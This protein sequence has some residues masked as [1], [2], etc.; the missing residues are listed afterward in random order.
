MD[1]V[2]KQID[3]VWSLL[4]GGDRIA[5]LTSCAHPA[6]AA[7]DEIAP[8]GP[9]VFAITRRFTLDPAA[10]AQAIRLTLDVVAEYRAT[11]TLIP[12]VSYDGNHWGGGD[13]PKGYER[14]G[15]PWSFAFHRVA[16]AGAT[17]S[18]GPHWSLALFGETPAAPC[19]C[20]CSLIP[21][22]DRTTHRLIWP[23]EERPVRYCERDQYTEPYAHTLTLQPG[24]TLTVTALVVVAP[25]T[26]P[27]QAHRRLLDEAWKMAYQPPRPRYSAEE[28]WQLGMTYLKEHTWAEEGPFR[29]FSIGLVWNGSRWHQRPTRK[30]EIGWAGQNAS[31]ACSLLADFR[32]TGDTTSRDMAVA[33]LDTWAEHGRFESGLVYAII[34][35]ITGLERPDVHDACNLGNAAADFLEAYQLAQGAGIDKPAWRETALGICDFM[36][37]DQQADGRYGRAWN[38]EGA[39]LDRDGTVGAFVIPAMLAAL[40]ETGDER[41]RASAER[42]FAHYYGGLETRG[43]VTAGALDTDCIDKE[44][45]HPLV[46]S[47]LG[48]YDLTGQ[49]EYIAAAE[50]ASYYIATWQY[51]YSVPIPPGSYLEAMGYDSFG[52]TSV[53]AQHHHLDPYAVRLLPLWLRLAEL[54]GNVLWAQ[55]ARAAWAHGLLGLSDGTLTLGGVTLP[56][57]TQCEGYFHT[58]WL[59]YGQTSFLLVAWPTAFRL[60]V[61]RRMGDWGVVDQS[62]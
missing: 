57:G 55:R 54:T 10:T 62:Y 51:H 24:E 18:A 47:A 29:G 17:Y 45:A 7:Q 5:T 43:F 3:G 28:T 6:G 16:I 35:P 4:A 32:R 60:E 56:R 58:R 1:C 37:R 52:G 2:W 12:A 20:A 46:E 19:G 59:E 8:R 36:L 30:Y 13:E 39:C 11:S 48:L 40:R 23:E 34:D 38:R 61:L 26:R 44:A 15:V 27:H 50:T 25:V 42:A 14:D 53:S 9:G 22:E 21:A 41:Y 31:L 33:T 49:A